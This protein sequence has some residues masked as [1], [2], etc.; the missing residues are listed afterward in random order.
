MSLFNKTDTSLAV[1]VGELKAKVDALEAK[2]ATLQ[3]PPSAPPVSTESL[4]TKVEAVIRALSKKD[5]ALYRH[6]ADEAKGML[7]LPNVDPD[8][9]CA[10]LI[11][12]SPRA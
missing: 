1:L 4:P 11:S 7:L 8:Q 6:L 10:A 5:H 9:V 2:V 3:A 12:G